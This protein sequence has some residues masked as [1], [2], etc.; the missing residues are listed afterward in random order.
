M[1]VHLRARCASEAEAEALLTRWATK[2]TRCSATGFIRATATRWK[3]LSVGKMAGRATLVVAESAT[4]GPAERISSVPGSSDYFLGGFMTYTR[5]MK[6][7]LLGIEDR[8]ITLHGA[9]SKE[10][11]EQMAAKARERADVTWAISITGNAGPTPDGEEE[12]VGSVFI[13]IAGP[14]FLGSFHRIWPSSDRTRVRAFA[15]Q[16][17]LDMLNRELDREGV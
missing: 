6:T 17:A 14:R 13:G 2:S 8:Y 5:R 1:Q 4:G 9:V 3:R 12:P 7:E 15:A 16:M 10:V 11:A